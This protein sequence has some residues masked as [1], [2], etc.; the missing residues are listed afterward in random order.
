[1]EVFSQSTGVLTVATTTPPWSQP[2]PPDLSLFSSTVI[3]Q[4]P[5][6]PDLTPG[7]GVE[8]V[9]PEYSHT[10]EKGEVSAASTKCSPPWLFA[11]QHRYTPPVKFLLLQPLCPSQ[12]YLSS[13]RGLSPY[14]GHRTGTPVNSPTHSLSTVRV[15]S[16]TPSFSLISLS[17][18][19]FPTLTLFSML[20]RYLKILLAALVL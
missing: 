11:S 6:N 20:P 7:C 5:A 3:S 8:W 18:V 12:C 1:M 4:G 2:M 13:D 10:M 19:E 15:C 9:G 17:G 16:R 14:T